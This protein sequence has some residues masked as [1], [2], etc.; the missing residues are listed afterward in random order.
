MQNSKV[1]KSTSSIVKLIGKHKII[2]TSIVIFLMCCTLNFILI[3]N[4]MK[5]LTYNF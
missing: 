5:I 2:T 3:Y 1:K 4:F